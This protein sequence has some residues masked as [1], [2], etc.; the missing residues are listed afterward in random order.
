MP[1][2]NSPSFLKTFSEAIYL[3]LN[4]PLVDSDNVQESGHQLV[5]M[6]PVRS[7][8]TSGHS[9]EPSE[10]N[11]QAEVYVH[12]RESS[13]SSTHSSLSYRYPSEC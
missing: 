8:R 3:L 7:S 6:T 11:D 5:E 12:G 13:I 2:S 1:S 4:T 9:M 10:K